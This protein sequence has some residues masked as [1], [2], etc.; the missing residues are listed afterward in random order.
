ME[1]QYT[2][3]MTITVDDEDIMKGQTV[4][5]MVLES[6]EDAPFQVDTITVS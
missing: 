1:R 2:V 3:A 5:D 6:L 4:D